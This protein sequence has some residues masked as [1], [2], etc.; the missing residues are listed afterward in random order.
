MTGAV[1]RQDSAYGGTAMR[2]SEFLQKN[3]DVMMKIINCMRVGVWITDG[4][5]NVVMVNDESINTGGLTRRE[6]IGRNMTEL[7]DIGYVLDESSVLNA[8]ESGKEE[9][10][11][12]EEGEGCVSLAV[13]VPLFCEGKIDLVICVERDITDIVMLENLLDKQKDIAKKFQNE[14]MDALGKNRGK[15][16]VMIVNN[17]NMIYLKERVKSIGALDATVM[18]TG[19]SG[20]GKEVV[21]NLIHKS[22]KR[23]DM[24][25]I[26]INCAAIPENLLESEFFGYEKGAFTG[27]DQKGKIGLFELADGGTLFLDEIGDLPMA[28]Q[29]KLLRVIQDREIRRIGGEVTIPVDVRLLVATNKNLK[30]EVEKGNFR[31]D[32]YY[33]LF[34][35]PIEVPPLRNRKEDIAQLTHRFLEEFKEQYSIEKEISGAAIRVLEE[36]DWPG[37]VRELRNIIE[38][39]VVSGAGNRISEFQVRRCLSAGEGNMFMGLARENSTASLAEMMNEYEKYIIETALGECENATEAARLLGI[40]K[41]TMSKKRK[42]HNI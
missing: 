29:S 35:I 17:S 40:D 19:E 42:K 3:Y 6:L 33:R 9:S 39:L 23:A 31:S 34:V 14:L 12:Q 21:A 7:I 20:T 4:D 28:L 27:A 10:I 2:Y 1:W 38:R 8:I 25:F 15:S 32:L 36:Y 11:I 24:P 18:I 16:D 41:S 37:N 5:G 22:S 13:S 26:K 30:E